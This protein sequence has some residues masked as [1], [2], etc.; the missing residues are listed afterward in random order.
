MSDIE[1]KFLIRSSGQILGPF[2]KNEVI[3][4][5][6]RGNISIF[7]EVAEP[8]NIWWYLQD[9]QDFKE[10]VQSMDFQARLTNFITQFSDKFSTISRAKKTLDKTVTHTETQSLD[11]KSQNIDSY[12]KQSAQEVKFKVVDQPKVVKSKA[13][14]KYTSQKDS[15]EIVRKKVGLIVK[16]SWQVIVVFALLVGGYI[17]YKE[18]VAPIQKKQELIYALRTDGL[19]FYKAGNYKKALFYFEEA[20]SKDLL[21]PEEKLLLASLFIQEDKLQKAELIVNELP[22]DSLLKDKN[23]F[24]LN[25]LISFFQ[26]D[27]TGA[28]ANFNR[29]LNQREKLSLV[30]LSILKWK[31]KNHQKSLAYLDQL[32][33]MAYDRDIV[34]YL[35]AL[36][37]LSQNQTG[38]LIDYISR[39]LAFDQ[40]HPL[41]KEYQQEFYFMLAYS[42]M[43]EQKLEEFKQAVYNL[44]NT[45][46]FFYKEYHYSSFTVV[47]ALNW[48]Y[49]YPYCKSIF[50]SDPQSNLL[51]ALYGFCYLKTGNFKQGTRYI[52][53]ARNREPDDAFFLSL[54]A[55]LLMLKADIVEMDQVLDLIDYSNLKSEQTLPLILKAYFFEQKQDWVRALSAWEELLSLSSEH[56]SGIAGVAFTSQQLGDYSK[57]D[58]Y[59]KRGLDKYPYYVRLLSY[60]R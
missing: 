54:Y 58:I 32:I 47:K 37:F 51:N 55:Y 3:D 36:N 50:E 59:R 48:N 30:N 26:K 57:S 40:N 5:I 39:E 14:E 7:D 10:A 13:Y 49:F 20:Y 4:L 44:L 9:H 42:Y 16:I 41:I 35:K 23:W 34:S 21:K 60:E 24:L 18:I 12:E 56:L 52:E 31:T 8:F 28:E 53:Q 46:P 25:G 19:R 22:R 29:A 38:V 2:D 33:K 6:K 45:D 1:K 15:E 17:V 27:F 43:K 11:Q